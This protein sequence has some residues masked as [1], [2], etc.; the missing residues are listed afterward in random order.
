MYVRTIDEVLDSLLRLCACIALVAPRRW[1]APPRHLEVQPRLARTMP[2]ALTEGI[3]VVRQANCYDECTLSTDDVVLTNAGRSERLF[4]P[5]PAED[6]DNS[7]FISRDARWLVFQR[8]NLHY[9]LVDLRT[10]WTLDLGENTA[11]LSPDGRFLV[12]WTGGQS[13]GMGGPPGLGHFRLLNLTTGRWRDLGKEMTKYNRPLTWSESGDRLTW[14]VT[15]T[16]DH[17]KDRPVTAPTFAIAPA[18]SPTTRP[19]FTSGLAT[20]SSASISLPSERRGCRTTT[21]SCI[22][23]GKDPGMRC[24]GTSWSV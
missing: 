6:G 8:R 2:A 1:R 20:R 18:D 17:G 14:Q 16:V 12:D 10:G 15:G 3:A 5:F 23:S 4:G 7:V 19:T 9:N 13:A 21:R 24:T 11:D 22:S